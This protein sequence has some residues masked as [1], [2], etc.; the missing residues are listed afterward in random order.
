VNS[1]VGAVVESKE[2][3]ADLLAAFDADLAD[4]ANGFVEYRIQRDT[5]GRPLLK[6]GEP[7]VEFG[8]EHHLPQELLE[9]YRGKRELWGNTL[10]DNFDYFGPLRHPKLPG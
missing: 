5:H 10:R 9:E 1:E 4:P 8:P 3:A 2:I 7:L 6:N